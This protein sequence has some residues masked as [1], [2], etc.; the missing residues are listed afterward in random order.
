M[1]ISIQINYIYYFDINYI[2][3]KNDDCN[4]TLYISDKYYPLSEN[5]ITKISYKLKKDLSNTKSFSSEITTA[6]II[7]ILNYLSD[8]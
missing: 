6:E 1:N 4:T 7:Q 2:D 8:K 3:Y 5:N